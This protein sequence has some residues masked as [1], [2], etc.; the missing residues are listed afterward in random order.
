[1][2]N[3]IPQFP[4]GTTP[5][6]QFQQIINNWNALN[7]LFEKDHTLFTDGD[8]ATQGHHKQVFYNA[9]VA[10]LSP[11]PT[12]TQAGSFVQTSAAPVPG[13]SQEV[14]RNSTSAPYI[15]S[16]IKAWGKVSPTGAPTPTPA[17]V[18]EGFNISAATTESTG[19]YLITFTTAL[20]NNNYIAICS[21]FGP[22]FNNGAIVTFDGV[23][24]TTTQF[25]I[26]SVAF[27]GGSGTVE[28]IMFVVLQT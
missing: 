24:A 6:P 17:V 7:N 5:I 10:G 15:V 21:S 3:F 19:Q 26:R 28:P 16:C 27:G 1:M 18:G 12:G 22:D 9:P 14:F 8:A 23:G 25:R 2:S 20:P 4:T 13:V 11:A